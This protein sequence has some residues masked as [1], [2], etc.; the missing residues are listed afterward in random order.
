MTDSYNNVIHDVC[1]PSTY[2]SSRLAYGQSKYPSYLF[3]LIWR[4]RP[5]FVDCLGPTVTMGILQCSKLFV[6][7]LSDE[8]NEMEICL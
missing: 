7:S 6:S 1:I 4:A 2:S 3:I 5:P 8:I